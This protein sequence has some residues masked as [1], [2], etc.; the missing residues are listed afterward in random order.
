M[1]LL[2]LELFTRDLE[3]ARRFYSDILD[4]KVADVHADGYTVMERGGVRIDLQP[5]E[6]LRPDHPVR[7]GAGER[8]GLGIEIVLEVEDVVAARDRVVTGGWPLASALRERPWGATDF[9]VLD[10]DGRY[11]RITSPS[12]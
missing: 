4:F 1:A 9:R 10:P 12:C 5:V 3:A 7:P 11:V 2:R 8:V 6:H